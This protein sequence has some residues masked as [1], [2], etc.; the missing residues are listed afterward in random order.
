ML[1]Q[2]KSA[3]VGRAVEDIGTVNRNGIRHAMIRLSGGV[4]IFAPWDEI[5]SVVTTLRRPV[6]RALTQ[7]VGSGKLRT[8]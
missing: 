2:L 3:L 1:E 8:G 7:V 6:Q 4:T 5:E